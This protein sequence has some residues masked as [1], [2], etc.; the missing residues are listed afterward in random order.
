MSLVRKGMKSPFEGRHWS[1]EQRKQISERQKGS[2]HSPRTQF[3][4][5]GVAPM[6]GRRQ[7]PEHRRRNSLSK[8]GV[9]AGEKHWNWQGGKTSD[10]Q[11]IRNSFEIREWRRHVFA[12]DDYT[13]QGCGKRGVELHADHELPFSM[14]QD[15]RFEILNGRA[16]CVGCH[17][18][19]PTF[20]SKILTY[21]TN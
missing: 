14:F 10:N 20:A 15:L 6:K 21:G 9:F 17:K 16:L 4:V 8:K 5:G 18:K 19:T 13:C 1:E 3:K 7:S 11:K 2:H 12:R